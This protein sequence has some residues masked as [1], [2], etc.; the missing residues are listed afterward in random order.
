MCGRYRLSRRKQVLAEH[1]DTDF[2]DLEWE[3]RFNVAPTQ[4]VPVLRL[5]NSGAISASLMRWG[6]IPSW[7]KD[8]KV[9][10][11]TINARSETAAE[12]PT[13]RGP[14]RNQRC[15]IPADAF[16][17]WKRTGKVKQ[18]YCFEVGQVALFAFA[19][20]WDCWRGPDGRAVETCTIL[21]TTAND[22]L[23]GIHDRMPV[24]LPPYQ[25]QAW[26]DAGMQNAAAAVEMLNP[27]DSSLMRRYAVSPRINLV[28]NDDPECATAVELPAAQAALFG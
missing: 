19:G 2:D 7:S 21:T 3:P 5:G 4:P 25:Y 16:Y 14:L 1:F 8:P 22:L 23:E 18:P 28:A 26:L 9:G 6:L 17:E 20:L 27:F 12:K 13:F 15:L 10:A 11:R 24:I